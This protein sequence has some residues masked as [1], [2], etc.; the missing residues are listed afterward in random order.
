M[1]TSSFITV[2]SLLQTWRKPV[3]DCYLHHIL[4]ITKK[5][6]MACSWWHIQSDK[7]Y[8][9]T[10]IFLIIIFIL[11]LCKNRNR[12]KF[13]PRHFYL[14]VYRLNFRLKFGWISTSYDWLILKTKSEIIWQ[15][16]NAEKSI[17]EKSV[18]H[19]LEHRIGHKKFRIFKWTYGEPFS[20]KFN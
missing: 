5:P 14:L 8:G 13:I 19:N 2:S 10:Y 16:Q 6:Q 20:H 18:F 4:M 17:I 7:S 9:P 3:N 12:I 11:H 15:L 1:W